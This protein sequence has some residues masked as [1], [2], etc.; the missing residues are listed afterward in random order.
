[1]PSL[2]GLAP[3]GSSEP[4]LLI[5]GSFPSVQ[6]LKLGQYYANARNHF[7]ELLG[8]LSGETMGTDYKVRLERLAAIRVTVWDLIASCEREGSL[9]QSIRAE[10]LNPLLDFLA[11]RP[12]IAGIALNG[13]KAAA[14]FIEGYAPELSGRGRYASGQRAPDPR[15]P[16]RSLRDIGAT[17]D[18]RPASLPGRLFRVSRL[19]STSP[20]PTRDFRQASDKL[21][22]WRAF[23]DTVM[24]TRSGL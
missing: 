20:V 13:G 6:S 18:W 12:S 1:M 9:D 8:R 15:R 14:A 19:P 17:Q 22:H 5:L 16:G 7:W 3:I 11:S 10:E 21:P 4:R 2:R 24:N 23:Y